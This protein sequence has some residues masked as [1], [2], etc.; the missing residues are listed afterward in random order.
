MAS[1][2]TSRLWE[3]GDIV[4]VLEAWETGVVKWEY[5]FYSVGMERDERNIKEALDELGEDGWELV[6][7]YQSGLRVFV[8][9][10]PVG[11]SQSK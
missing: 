10:R 6:T 1:G 4:N 7:V 5:Y 3:I 11:S 8:L 2:A 9:K